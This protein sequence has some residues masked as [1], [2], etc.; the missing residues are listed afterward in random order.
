M[1]GG[2]GLEG[3]LNRWRVFSVMHENKDAAS[4]ACHALI[5]GDHLSVN[6]RTKVPLA[7]HA[8]LCN[9]KETLTIWGIPPVLCLHEMTQL[10]RATSVGVLTFA[11]R[12]AGGIR[13]MQAPA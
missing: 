9:T 10:H 8:T 5:D 4:P 7:L 3:C 6:K 2:H 13:F 11:S 12:H 1:S